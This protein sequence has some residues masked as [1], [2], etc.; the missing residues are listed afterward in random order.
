MSHRTTRAHL[1][2]INHVSFKPSPFF[3]SDSELLSL[4]HLNPCKSCLDKLDRMDL[5]KFSDCLYYDPSFHRFMSF[6]VRVQLGTP[7]MVGYWLMKNWSAER[8]QEV[9]G[10]PRPHEMKLTTEDIR[11][12]ST[13]K[14][15]DVSLA[16]LEAMSDEDFSVYIT[17]PNFV[18]FVAQL[19]SGYPPNLGMALVK[20][21]ARMVS[22]G[23]MTVR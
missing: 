3:F 11:E 20:F 6:I 7:E 2:N 4:A 5:N 8:R 22:D 12:L 18:K 19:K 10:S 15:T 23:F 21:W 14:V 1:N 16:K 17:D 9:Y 13:K